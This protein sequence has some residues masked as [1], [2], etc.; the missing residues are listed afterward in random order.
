MGIW[1]KEE[2]TSDKVASERPH[3]G[4]DIR[5]KDLKEKGSRPCAYTRENSLCKRRSS[6]HDLQWD[7]VR[8]I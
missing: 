1:D 6:E 4:G 3:L 7:L 5:L 2:V 8:P